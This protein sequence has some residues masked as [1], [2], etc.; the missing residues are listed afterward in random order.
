[1]KPKE[2]PRPTFYRAAWCPDS[3][4]VWILDENVRTTLGE[5]DHDRHVLMDEH[6][7]G[8]GEILFVRAPN[9]GY[10]RPLLVRGKAGITMPNAWG[11]E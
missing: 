5:A 10:A 9:L 6:G 8:H 1:M 3:T 7:G 4:K 11:G 2:K